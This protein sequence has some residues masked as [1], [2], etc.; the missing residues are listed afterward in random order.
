MSDSEDDV[1]IDNVD[2]LVENSP[3]NS[4]EMSDRVA[5]QQ[6]VLQYLYTSQ[7]ARTTA[8]LYNL[9]QHANLQTRIDLTDRIAVIRSQLVDY[10]YERDL[11]E[12]EAL[13]RRFA[14]INNDT[15]PQE[16]MP[17]PQPRQ[18]PVQPTPDFLIDP[19]I[20]AESNPSTST[21]TAAATLVLRSGPGSS[22][23]RTPRAP[24]SIRPADLPK[25]NLIR[26]SD[27]W[28]LQCDLCS[29]VR[30][31]VREFSRHVREG[32]GGARPGFKVIACDPSKYLTW[33]GHDDNGVEYSGNIV[34]ASKGGKT[35]PMPCAAHL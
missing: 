34:A 12:Q 3:P 5:V 31:Q 24:N 22:T 28:G 30:N 35:V 27:G 33:Y 2:Y 9:L 19:Q 14:L 23:A 10:V 29:H 13:V 4:I 25:K 6:F 7:D 8:V 1:F 26:D 20:L 17:E 32:S 15:G 16:T 18:R 11:P 21:S